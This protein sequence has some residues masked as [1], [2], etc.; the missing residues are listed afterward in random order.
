MSLI[1]PTFLI[2]EIAQAHEGSLGIA[3]SYCDAVKDCGFDA[4]K[5]QMHIASEESTYDEEFRIPFSSQDSTRYAYWERTSFSLEELIIIA[6]KC[7]DLD[8]PLGMSPFSAKALDFCRKLNV[9]FIK[10]G[11]GEVFNSEIVDELNSA[12]NVFV[13]NVYY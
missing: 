10:I 12:D 9:D 11:S 13:W 4:I 7:K 1:K 8:L 6:K 3:L 2:A 5:F